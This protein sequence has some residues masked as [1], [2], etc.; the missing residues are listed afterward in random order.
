[1][2]SSR[3]PTP[4]SPVTQPGYNRGRTSPNKGMKLPPEILAPDEVWKLLDS[5][6]TTPT[7]LRNRAIVWMFYGVGIKIGEL[8]L[9]EVSHY[10]RRARR[11][12]IPA[13][14]IR[15]ERKEPLDAHAIEMVD[16]WLT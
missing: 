12:T 8:P 10:D 9:L 6:G 3:R 11:L 4:R 1:M 13:T 2:S 15:R 7:Q 14:G 5:F 16:A